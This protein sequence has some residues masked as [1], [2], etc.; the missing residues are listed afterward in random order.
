MSTE[1][2]IFR[3][4]HID[5]LYEYD[6]IEVMVDDRNFHDNS[7]GIFSINNVVEFTLHRNNKYL[8]FNKE[9]TNYE[10]DPKLYGYIREQIYKQLQKAGIRKVIFVV[11]PSQYDDIYKKFDPKNSYMIGFTT[12]DEAL[13]WIKQDLSKQIFT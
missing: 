12:R 5:I 11:K 4:I 2:E 1:T 7:S 10:I 13:A 8:I 3:G 6:C 9:N